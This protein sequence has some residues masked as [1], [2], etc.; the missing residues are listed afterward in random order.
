MY[1]DIGS[2][3]IVLCTRLDIHSMDATVGGGGGGGG[4]GSCVM[5]MMGPPMVKDWFHVN[6]P[7]FQMR[8]TKTS[9]IEKSLKWSLLPEN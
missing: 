5:L 7:V 6:R 2:C 9:M 3:V 8:C 1:N 4:I